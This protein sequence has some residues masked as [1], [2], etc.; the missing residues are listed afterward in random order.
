M[1]DEPLAS[2]TWGPTRRRDTSPGLLGSS[3]ACEEACHRWLT[4]DSL[5]F[6]LV[7]QLV[8]RAPEGLVSPRSSTG[9]LSDMEA[10][11]QRRLMHSRLPSKASRGRLPKGWT[12]Y[13]REDL[14]ALKV[15]HNGARLAQ[16]RDSWRHGFQ[17]LLGHTQHDAGNVYLIDLIECPSSLTCVLAGE[18]RGVL[19][20]RDAG[21]SGTLCWA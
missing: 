18:Q 10:V 4:R 1:H 20:V 11:S 14:E 16:D 9:S 8:S 15:L 7:G 13:M 6:P 12:D 3:A 5:C 19:A 17:E 2:C 21:G